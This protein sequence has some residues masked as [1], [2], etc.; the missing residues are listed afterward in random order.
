MHGGGVPTQRG[1]TDTGLR[2]T[3]STDAYCHLTARAQRIELRGE[4]GEGGRGLRG[5][6]G[7]KVRE[8]MCKRVAYIFYRETR[9]KRDERTS[10][11]VCSS[12]IVSCSLSAF[13]SASTPVSI[14]AE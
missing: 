2:E 3:L 1:V 14:S 12:A 13:A 9:T 7:R 6:E 4:R 8:E 5:K 11:R 10:V